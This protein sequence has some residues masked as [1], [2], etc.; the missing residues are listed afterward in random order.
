V[1]VEA[2][3]I[4][5]IEPP[6]VMVELEAEVMA[7][8]QMK[9]EKMALQTLEAAVAVEVTIKHLVV[10]TMPVVLEVLVLL[11]LNID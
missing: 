7:Q 2:E 5:L 6:A 1:A 4:N 9:L 11:Q 10:E 8:V 3:H